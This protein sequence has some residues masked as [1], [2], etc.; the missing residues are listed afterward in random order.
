MSTIDVGQSL[1]NL[2][3]ERDAIQLYDALASIEKRPERAEAF[4]RIAGNE[5]RHA[6]IWAA[7]L[8]ELG[9][10]VP[11]TSAP[12]A[13]VRFII[14]LARLLG[15]RAVS[16]LVQVLEGD[17]DALYGSQAS[18]EVA[19][20]GADEREH[21]QIWQQMDGKP[22]TPVVTATP[23]Q[24]AAFAT[25]SAARDDGT[26]ARSGGLKAREIGANERWHRSSRS[27]T[28]RASIFGAS[29][30]LV[31]NLS[32]VMGVAGASSNDPKFILLAG[33]AG[34]LAG[35]GSMAAGEYIS[36]TSQRE[37]FEHQIAL[38]RAE[39]EILPEAEEAE[40]A[41]IYRAKGLTD[42]E[43]TAFA[44]RLMQDPRQALDTLIREELGLDPDELGSTWGAA[45]G[46]FLAF[47]VG[48]VIPVVPF[49][50]G[51]G[52]LAFGLS[53]GLSLVALFG[54]GAGVSLVTGR[55]L[56][57]S[58]VRQVMIGMLA[59]GITYAVGLL[60]GVSVG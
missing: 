50:F 35:A 59:A 36:M 48:A 46:S 32:L 53:I 41:A 8:G 40:L 15:T 3:L 44:S 23:A 13:R 25:I 52:T 45:G 10:T 60:V 26:L 19:S 22:A 39:F 58:G 42:E 21:A 24:A 54:V 7:R 16:G 28:L 43:A 33:I 1:A 38:E 11:P 2:K 49:L 29:D 14:L 5:R 18:P 27:G 30:G 51:G 4:R 31:S 17:E 20:I 12:R 55:S 34:L 57:Y 6:E 56:V 47:A 9:A 37:Q